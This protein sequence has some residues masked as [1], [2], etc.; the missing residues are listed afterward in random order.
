M[1]PCMRG[2]RGRRTRRGRGGRVASLYSRPSLLFVEAGEQAAHP[3]RV[4]VARVAGGRPRKPNLTRER[5]APARA[6]GATLHTN[7]SF[8]VRRRVRREYCHDVHVSSFICPRGARF[9]SL[10]RDNAANRTVCARV[11]SCCCLLYA[12][13][14]S[15]IVVTDALCQNEGRL[16]VNLRVPPFLLRLHGRDTRDASSTLGDDQVELSSVHKACAFGCPRRSCRCSRLPTICAAPAC[17]EG[18]HMLCY[19]PSTRQ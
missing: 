3:P 14:W 17:N 8:G 9:A 5:A 1:P 15:S 12:R 13:I 16:R 19:A 4:T 10:A 2:R 6:A 7:K 18:Q 11:T